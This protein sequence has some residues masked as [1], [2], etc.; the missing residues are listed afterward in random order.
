MDDTGQVCVLGR[1]AHLREERGDLAMGACLNS[2]EVGD[3]DAVDQFDGDVRRTRIV[4]IRAMRTR[5]D[6]R[7]E[8][9]CDAR[10]V[11]PREC[12][13]FA[14]ESPLGTG[15]VP[16][17]AKDLE[18]HLAAADA[19][20]AGAIDDR[21]GSDAQGLSGKGREFKP[22]NLRQ[23]RRRLAQARGVVKRHSKSSTGIHEQEPALNFRIRGEHRPHR[24]IERCIT[25]AEFRQERIAFAP[26]AT[27]CLS[28]GLLDDVPAGGIHGW[29]WL[30]GDGGW[31]GRVACE[32]AA[33]G[34]EESVARPRSCSWDQ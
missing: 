2:R 21:G 3:A 5:R 15:A 22:G 34:L 28:E 18:G 12:R 26:L 11:K 16:R 20:L 6:A 23:P 25:H 4:R 32:R 13:D 8:D 14:G 19:Q 31:G 9:M 7:G 10:M 1:I 17:A 29:G 30:G 24:S 27:E 33:K